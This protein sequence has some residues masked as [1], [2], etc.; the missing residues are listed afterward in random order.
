MR[1]QKHRALPTIPALFVLAV[2]SVTACS[3]DRG[4]F[5]PQNEGASASAPV[6]APSPLGRAAIADEAM[7]AKDATLTTGART[8]EPQPERPRGMII[9]NGDASIEVDSLEIAV[10]AVRQLAARLGGFVGNVSMSTGEYAVRSATIEIKIPSTRFDEAFGGLAPIGKVEHSN[11]TALD[12]GEEFVDVTARVANARRLEQRLVTLLA[13]RTG[14]LEDVLAVERELARVR[15]QIERYEGRL[16]YLST[17]VDTSTL[18]VT[19]HEPV[20][21]VNPNP[22]TSIIGESFRHMWRNFV[23]FVAA[24][25]EA[26]GVLIPVGLL[27][28][29]VVWL[30]RRRKTRRAV[31]AVGGNA[32]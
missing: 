9:R 8:P 18:T 26:L 3:E 7:Q 2:L 28:W 22:G 32:A 12:V 27:G 14:K 13:T 11:S 10:A 5:A 1:N 6:M 20:P 16:R 4:A 30:W 25:I 31:P 23:R 24:G 19:I 17:R 15:E 29:V 21:V